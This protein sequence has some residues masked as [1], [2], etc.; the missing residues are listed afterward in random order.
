[1]GHTLDPPNQPVATRI[2]FV[3]YSMITDPCRDEWFGVTC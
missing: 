3:N 2:P 1:M